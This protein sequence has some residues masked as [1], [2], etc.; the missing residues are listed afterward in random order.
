VEI[1]R[2]SDLTVSSGETDVKSR[3]V[4]IGREPQGA[5]LWRK[6]CFINGP[7]DL[8][9][10]GFA[11]SDSRLLWLPQRRR[12]DYDG[13][14][15]VPRGVNR[16]RWLAEFWRG[17]FEGKEAGV[18]RSGCG[19]SANPSPGAVTAVPVTL[20]VIR[21]FAGGDSIRQIAS[22]LKVDGPRVELRLRGTVSAILQFLSC[23]SSKLGTSLPTPFES[24]LLS[25][26]RYY[27]VR[28]AGQQSAGATARRPRRARFPR[29]YALPI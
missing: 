28:I 15:A 23:R 24:Q 5:N 16:E 20:E 25:L 19:A 8:S 4:E 14:A 1:G 18:G 27:A 6:Q 26:A 3:I 11:A 10:A 12:C 13:P 7:A 21:Q 2:P 22:E 17:L 29:Q 9:R